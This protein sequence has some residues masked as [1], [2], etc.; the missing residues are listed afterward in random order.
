MQRDIAFE[1][2]HIVTGRVR[3]PD[4]QALLREGIANEIVPVAVFFLDRFFA[5]CLYHLVVDIF[6]REK[7]VSDHRISLIVIDRIPDILR[8]NGQIGD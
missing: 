1:L 2:V 6:G 8:R 4:L 3:H 7:L 5:V